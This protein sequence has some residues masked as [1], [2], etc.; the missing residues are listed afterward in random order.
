MLLVFF[1]CKIAGFQSFSYV[2]HF[3]FMF[4]ALQNLA[5]L[6]AV[7]FNKHKSTSVQVK[8]DWCESRVV[9]NGLCCRYVEQW[10]A[11]TGVPAAPV[12]V[13]CADATSQSGLFCTCY[14]VCEKLSLEG[15]VSVFHTVKALRLKQPGIIA[16]LVSRPT[17]HCMLASLHLFSHFFHASWST[18][19][20]SKS[21]VLSVL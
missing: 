4:S 6:P 2:L 10:K 13:Q 18:S 14:V 17:V 7:L 9:L 8:F 15:H 5:V 11:H 19:F 20:F 16:S 3:L 21:L 1:L 12:V